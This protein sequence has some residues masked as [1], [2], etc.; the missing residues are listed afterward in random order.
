VKPNTADTKEET[1]CPIKEE[2]SID[3]TCPLH[4]RV[5][6]RIYIKGEDSNNETHAN[7][8]GV[9]TSCL[10]SSQQAV[11]DD[12]ANYGNEYGCGFKYDIINE[13]YIDVY[14]N[15]TW[16]T[17]K[18]LDSLHNTGGLYAPQIRVKGRV[19]IQGAKSKIEKH[20]TADGVIASCLDLRQPVTM[21][22]QAN[23]GNEYGCGFMYDI[24]D[25]D[26]ID[27][28]VDDTWITHE[29]N[30]SIQ[31]KLPIVQPETK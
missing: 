9:I 25:E 1:G 20:S 6:G 12:Q 24:I 29:S 21:D 3:G 15:G 7:T 22:D 17:H 8:D 14:V 18:S 11:M 13:D 16:I 27:V 23:Y 30:D 10:K 31:S 2:Y 28:Y 26:H 4:I 5:K 19:Y